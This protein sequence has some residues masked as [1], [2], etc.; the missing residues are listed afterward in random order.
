L[1]NLHVVK[2][3]FEFVLRCSQE[4]RKSI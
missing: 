3:F 2:L 4:F 1:A